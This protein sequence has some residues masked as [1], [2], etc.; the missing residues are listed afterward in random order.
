[1]SETYVG[2]SDYAPNRGVKPEENTFPSF[3]NNY[4][5]CT[6]LSPVTQI[7]DLPANPCGTVS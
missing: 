3:V 1:M 5:I 6:K 4:F 2:K 7:S